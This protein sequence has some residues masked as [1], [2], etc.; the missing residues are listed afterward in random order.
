MEDDTVVMYASGPA[1]L[2]VVLEGRRATPPGARGV[3]GGGED[4][5]TKESDRMPGVV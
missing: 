3:R 1:R 2:A 4:E 5:G